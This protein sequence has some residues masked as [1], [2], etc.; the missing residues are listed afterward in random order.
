MPGFDNNTVYADNV[1]FRGVQ[2]VVGQVTTDGQLLIG[3]TATPNIKVGTLG[4]SDGSITWTAGSGTLT[5]QVTGGTSVLKTLTPDSGGAQSPTAG[6]INTP[7]SGSITTVGSG[8]TITTQLTG[9]TNHAVLIGA[10]TTTITKVGPVASTGAMLQSNGLGSDPGFS[11]STWPATTTINQLLYSSAANTVAGLTAANSASLVSTSAGVPVWSSTMTNG[12]VII[13]STGA[14]PTAASLTAGAGIAITNAAG[15]IT[16]AASGGI[17]TTWTDV[18]GATQ[19][20]AVNN[21]YFTDRGAGVTYTLP[22]T[23]ALGDLI[24]IDGKLG[25]TTIAQNAGQSIRF[26][27]AITTVGVTGSAVGTNLGDCVSL[28]CSTAGAST[29]WI[30]ENFNGNWT[31]N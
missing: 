28:R 3:S 31:I 26:S 12:Q 24:I 10:G 27:S 17:V 9:L 11:T 4:S 21:G 6:N 29:V 19:A 23:A 16:I 1:D 14:T 30:A 13:G 8:S 15:S 18:T 20:L 25:L 2:P 5:G 7:G 22:A